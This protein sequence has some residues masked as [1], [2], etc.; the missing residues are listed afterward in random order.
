MKLPRPPCAKLPFALSRAMVLAALLP[1]MLWLALLWPGVARPSGSDLVLNLLCGAGL[2]AAV[3][4]AVHHAE[5]LAERLGEPFGTL[6]L[7][8]AITIIETSLI[9]MLMQTGSNGNPTLARD[10]VY[11]AVMIICNGVIGLCLLA[12]ALR[13]SVPVF[14]VEGTTPVLSV[15]ATLVGLTLIVPRF[16]ISTPGPTLNAAQL[17]FAGTVSLLLYMVF[18][19]VQ[20]VRHRDHFV[21]PELTQ[22]PALT[23]AAASAAHAAH[24][25]HTSQPH[26]PSRAHARISFCLLLPAL[27]TVVGLAKLLTPSIELAVQA[28]HAPKSVVGIVISLL[29]LLPETGAALRAA[30]RNQMQ[31]SFNLAL[32]SAL[33]TIGLTIPAVAAVSFWLNLPLDLGLPAKEIALLTLTLLVASMTLARGTTTVLQ[34]AV[35][36]VLFAAFLFLAIVP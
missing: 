9:V 2:I 25:A 29:V 33:A 30:L 4:A 14:R 28:M 3:I 16:T 19:F 10:T 36:L 26:R 1:L 18:I 27:I 31:R 35:H 7:A 17:L 5:I 12:A 34:G 11:A 20:T 13:Y 22:M 15:L 8:L 24:A 23:P 6:L 21:A 32:G